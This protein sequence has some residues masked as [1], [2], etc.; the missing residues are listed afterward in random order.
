MGESAIAEPCA[1]TGLN[2]LDRNSNY[3][4]WEQLVEPLGRVRPPPPPPSL[5]GKGLELAQRHTARSGHSETHYSSLKVP[6]KPMQQARAKVH[7]LRHRRRWES[8]KKEKHG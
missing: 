4:G 2:L 7:I 3:W 5:H 1:G 8:I 6:T